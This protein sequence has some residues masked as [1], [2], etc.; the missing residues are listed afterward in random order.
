MEHH[1]YPEEIRT[2]AQNR[3]ARHLLKHLESRYKE[4]C[5]EQPTKG[6]NEEHRKACDDIAKRIME[7]K[8]ELR[9]MDTDVPRFLGGAMRAM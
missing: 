5:C 3:T 1:F 6:G 7:I 8:A 4:L 2:N 9:G